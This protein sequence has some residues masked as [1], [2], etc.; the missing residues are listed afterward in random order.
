[1]NVTTDMPPADD[2]QRVRDYAPQMEEGFLFMEKMRKDL[3]QECGE[4]LE[5]LPEAAAAAKVEV[6]F[7]TS[8]P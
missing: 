8:L 3:L 4:R 6:A 7:S 2:L 5:S 1:M